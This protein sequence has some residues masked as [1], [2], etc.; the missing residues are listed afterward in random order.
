M[1]TAKGSVI[2]TLEYFTVLLELI[3][4]RFKE[5]HHLLKLPKTFQLFGYGAFDE[6]KPNLKSDFE[7]LTAEF[8]NGK[9][10]YDKSREAEKGKALIK[11]NEHYKSILMLYLNFDDVEQFISA[12]SLSEVENEKQLNLIHNNDDNKTYYYLN[13][14]FGEENTIIKGQTVISNNW[15]KIK[16]TFMYPLEDGTIREHYSHGNI[17]RQDDMLNIRTRTLSGGKYIDGASEVYYIGH[18][19][20]SDIN[21][22]VGTYCTFDFYTNTVAGKTILEKCESKALME[23]QS[24]SPFIPPYIAQE[25]LSTRIVNNNIVP[26]NAFELSNKSPYASVFEKLPGT[27]TLHFNF[28]AKTSEHLIFNVS[29]KNYEITPLTENVYLESDKLELLNKGTVVNFHFV[30]SGIFALERVNIYFKSYFLKEN[31]AIQEGVFSG[32][33]NENRLVNGSVR[34]AFKSE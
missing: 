27:Y 8:I 4:N 5:K 22:L 9:Y 7:A 12:Q 20:P 34:F 13:Y 14:Y 3:Q 16:H 19:T 28:D 10:L 30:F 25:V 17:S 21:Y 29:G 31:S 18:K 23:E 6:N 2:F 32:I 24:K 11:I 33:D 26:R 1:N 15:K